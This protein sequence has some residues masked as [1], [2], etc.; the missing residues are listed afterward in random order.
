MC[1]ELKNSRVRAKTATE[2]IVCYKG[3]ILYSNGKLRTPYQDVQIEIGNTY[4]SDVIKEGNTI[5]IGLHSFV[6][7]DD[8]KKRG[9]VWRGGGRG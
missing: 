1:L 3:L 9:A 8:L 7:I 4:K 6:T 2:D 5:N